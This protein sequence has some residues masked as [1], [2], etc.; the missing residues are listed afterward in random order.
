MSW[1]KKLG[2]ILLILF[3][4][5]YFLV[6]IYSFI[7]PI[8]IPIVADFISF[9]SVK[10]SWKSHDRIANSL[11]RNIIAGE[12]QKFCNHHGVDWQ[13]LASV[14]S[15]AKAGDYSSGGSTINMQVAK[16]LFYWPLPKFIR[17][18]LEIPMAL[19]I[20]LVW[21]K[22]RTMEVYTNIAEFGDGVYGA[23]AASKHHFNK[24]AYSL[25]PYESSM[26]AASLP[27]PGYRN[28]ARPN[29]YVRYYSSHIRNASGRID[30][31][32]LR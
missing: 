7:P 10:W 12:D 18:P 15:R 3:T 6:V 8:S 13:S 2:R 21:S 1:R 17:K 9:K 11:A 14:I 19:W 24:S 20:D 31:S 4:L 27:S 16:N 32:C 5:P 25:T 23:E 29:D 30:G 22:Q 26:L 28:P